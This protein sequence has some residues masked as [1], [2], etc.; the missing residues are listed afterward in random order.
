VF[1][2][3]TRVPWRTIITHAPTIVDAARRL[4]ANTRQADGTAAVAIRRLGP[5]DVYRAVARL[6][7]RE[8][9]QAALIADLAREVQ[10]IA[11]GVEVL[12]SRLML[13]TVGSVVSL[14]LAT[15]A[16]IAALTR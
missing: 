2:A 13:A 8:I 14:L 9:E 1:W 4:Y 12:R 15:A 10:Q 7:E 6:E 5:D 16:L 3:L 11:T